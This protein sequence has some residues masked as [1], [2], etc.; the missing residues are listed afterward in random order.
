MQGKLDRVCETIRSIDSIAFS[1]A[2]HLID[3]RPNHIFARPYNRAV[4][5]PCI[6]LHSNYALGDVDS[7]NWSNDYSSTTR[8]SPT[9]TLT[10]E[11]RLGRRGGK[12]TPE[13]ARVST[14][15][16]YDRLIN[17]L[18]LY[19][20]VRSFIP[21]TI[22]KHASFVNAND[23]QSKKGVHRRI[24]RIN[25]RLLAQRDAWTVH[26]KRFSSCVLKTFS[27]NFGYQ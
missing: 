13:F 9:S 6:Y 27:C 26:C 19:I 25:R 15:G 12:Q 18:V 16:L 5:K 17:L 22:K 8:R 7:A 21:M 23:N 3:H 4:R 14:R 11:S 20:G 10:Q 1:L 24:N 2:K